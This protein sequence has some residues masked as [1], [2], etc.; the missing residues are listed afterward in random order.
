VRFGRF[1]LD[2]ANSCLLRDGKAVPLAPTPFAVL[3][4][5]ARHPGALLGKNALLDQVWGH[6]FVSDSVLKTVISDLRT[7]LDDDARQPRFIETVSRRGY[8]F[9]AI[10]IAI[11]TAAQA[12]AVRTAAPRVPSF[13]ARLD[14]LSRLHRTWDAA[15]NGT[16]AVVWVA[17][18]PGIGKTMLV[19]HF[20]ASLGDIACARG[21]CVEHYGAGEPYL[22]VLEALGRLCRTEDQVPALL[23]AVAPTWLL[24]LPWLSSAEERDSLR[25]EL[26]GVS[27]SRMLR[28][29]GELIDRYTEGRP[30]LLVTEDLHWSDRSTTQL[31]D[32]IARRRG[33]GRLMWLSTFRTAEVVAL[34][35][36][37]NPVRQEL[38]LH[39]LCEEIALDPFTE[40]EVADYV[41]ERSPALAA[42]EAFVR[43]L[44]ERT[45]GVPLFVASVLTEAI[46]RATARDAIDAGAA[47]QFAGVAVPENLTGI[48]DHYIAGLGAEQRAVLSAAAVCGVEFRVATVS[49]VLER[50]GPLVGQACEELAREGL[51]L[52]A[53]RGGDGGD[54]SEPSYA[55]SHSLFRQVLYERTAPAARAQLHRH[56]G[57]ALEKER[58]AGVPVAAVELAMHF[59]RGREP[60]TALR[61]YAEAAAGALL[62]L[63]AA[64]GMSLTERG[65]TLLDQ[66]PAGTDRD[67]LEITLA[68]LRG[69]SAFQLLG[70]GSETKSALLRAYARLRDVPQHPLRGL[71]NHGCGFVLCLRGEYAEALAVAERGLSSATDDPGLLLAA[72]TVQG[73]VHMLQGRPLAARAW[74]D[75][76]LPALDSLDTAPGEAFVADPAV[77]LLGLLSTQLLHLG[78]AQQARARMQQAYARAQ[79][80]RQ[81]VARMIAIWFDALLEL[82]LSNVERV[83]ALAAEM[84]ALVD[85]FSVAQGR[86]AAQW[87]G[88][89]VDA[90]T[91][92]P[93]EGHRRI[94]EAHERN[95][96]LGMLAGGSEN[97]GYAAEALVLAGDWDAAEAQLRE[98]LQ[99]AS[100]HDERV[101]LPQ[102]LMIES[103]IS[104]AR[105]EPQAADA[106]VRRAIAEA[107]EQEAPWLELLARIELCEHES[108]T[109]EDRDALAR[110]VDRMPEAGET[111][112]VKKARALL[113]TTKPRPMA[114]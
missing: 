8:R 41:A 80:L 65:L 7:L 88:G 72:C 33:S 63:S 9:I 54:G 95:V 3:C 109:A 21:Q 89:W 34:D 31:I 62:G 40:A 20:V 42:D 100:A 4:T 10:P 57:A 90:R 14:A 73:Q 84:Q 79:Q 44:H 60:M 74:L 108:A 99:F 46:A 68:T 69:A 91:G 102:L 113:D 76:G 114:A 92:Q 5:L 104:R 53:P 39:G 107:R 70:V 18:E 26:A 36:P 11:P 55:F 82:R 6:Q 30:L 85:R 24:Q 67:A 77:M 13:I 98:A 71:L 96:R 47:A 49:H 112:A 78:L 87:F 29:M 106:S 58:D 66:A 105:G 111:A 23:R 61:Y 35:H 25:R 101:Y 75:R 94:R 52:R 93:R 45:D 86:T 32:Y 50:S 64:E 12:G 2:E 28:E 51:W 81:P 37:L 17:G 110:L 19:E 38:R 22:P 27:P 59:E 83:A 103:A 15:C 56:V 97:L 1:E 48:I 16:R 43:A